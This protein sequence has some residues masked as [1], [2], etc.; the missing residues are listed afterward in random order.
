MAGN[1]EGKD[2]VHGEKRQ[3]DGRTRKEEKGGEREEK[4]WDLHS[5]ANTT[6]E[7]DDGARRNSASEM[8]PEKSV[9]L[10]RLC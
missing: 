4:G 8:K 9:A 1:N 7:R 3:K 10:C 5:K 2:E 6:R